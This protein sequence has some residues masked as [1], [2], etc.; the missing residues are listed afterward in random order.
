MASTKYA[1]AIS[2]TKNAKNE[3]LFQK[4][5]NKNKPFVAVGRYFPMKS[6]IFGVFTVF[7]DP[8]KYPIRSKSRV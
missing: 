7:L 5:V 6:N 3:M 4:M 2:A 1:Y 8:N